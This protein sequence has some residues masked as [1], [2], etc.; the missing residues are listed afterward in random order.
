[1]MAKGRIDIVARTSRYVYVIELKLTKN[2]GVKAAEQQII[3]NQYAEPFKSDGRE[4]V[5]LA[6]EL[7]DSGK[8]LMDWAVV[9]A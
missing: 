6:I 3:E 8:G 9:D 4:V 7:E 2:G 5:A 1:M